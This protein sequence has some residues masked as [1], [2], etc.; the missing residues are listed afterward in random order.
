MTMI[1][2]IINV[3]VEHELHVNVLLCKN[4]YI[5]EEIAVM[6]L[7]RKLGHLTRDHFCLSDSVPFRYN[8]IIIHI[9]T[10]VCVCDT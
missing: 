2:I 6:Y 1:I 4:I 8:I 9:Y 3:V 5:Y 10:I 7:I